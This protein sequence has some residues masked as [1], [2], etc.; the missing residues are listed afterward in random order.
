[1]RIRTSDQHRNTPVIV[2]SGFE[3]ADQEIPFAVKGFLPK[4][5]HPDQLLG[6]LKRLGV[7]IRALKYSQ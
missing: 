7:P 6:E 1:M 3:R 5:V 4:P 2:I